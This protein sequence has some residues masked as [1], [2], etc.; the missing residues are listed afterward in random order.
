MSQ[1]TSTDYTSTSQP[2]GNIDEITNSITGV[3]ASSVLLNAFTSDLYHTPL[4]HTSHEEAQD[5]DDD[6]DQQLHEET[7]RILAGSTSTPSEDPVLTSTLELRE[8]NQELNLGP[9]LDDGGSS[10][11]QTNSGRN[12]LSG[13]GKVLGKRTTNDYSGNYTLGS[14]RP[15]IN[16]RTSSV[17]RSVRVYEPRPSHPSPLQSNP[18][19]EKSVVRDISTQESRRP[20]A[21]EPQKRNSIVRRS[22]SIM[23]NTVD[24]VKKAIRRRSGIYDIRQG[25]PEPE[26]QSSISRARNNSPV[27]IRRLPN[28][29][30]EG[31][32]SSPNRELPLRVTNATPTDS[33]GSSARIRP[34]STYVDFA[35]PG[36]EDL[37]DM[38]ADVEAIL[39]PRTSSA[40]GMSMDEEVVDTP[41]AVP[42]ITRYSA[43]V[44]MVPRIDEEEEEDEHEME[45][46]EKY[47]SSSRPWSR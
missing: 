36:F 17:P 33:S 3:G 4:D 28:H 18:S 15:E 29:N 47:N 44:D 6:S 5:K 16:E 45:N 30:F 10:S 27:S 40:F 22:A 19:H 26:T 31:T 35:T 21:G 12:A 11:R 37:M 24:G 23:L 1:L 41:P 8:R 2:R 7:F 9:S 34:S 13:Q 20:A 42:E 14:Q 43:Y 46:A 32:S 38:L 25:V 39:N